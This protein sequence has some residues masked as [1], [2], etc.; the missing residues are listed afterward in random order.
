MVQKIFCSER[1]YFYC[2]QRLSNPHVKDLSCLPEKKDQGNA[3]SCP[4]AAQCKLCQACHEINSL[5]LSTV[6]GSVQRTYLCIPLFWH[7]CSSEITVAMHGFSFKVPLYRPKV[8]RRML[9]WACAEQWLSRTTCTWFLP[10]LLWTAGLKEL[11][12][13]KGT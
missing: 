6:V 13:P 5:L 12:R 9:C 4:D 8:D 10:G 3:W 1:K 11:E 7:L 2:I